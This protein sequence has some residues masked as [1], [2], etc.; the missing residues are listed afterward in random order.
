MRAGESEEA[1]TTESSVGGAGEGG[2]IDGP[3]SCNVVEGER[4]GAAELPL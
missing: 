4:A 3:P 1:E 2:S